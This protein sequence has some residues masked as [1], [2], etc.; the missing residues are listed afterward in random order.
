MRPYLPAA[1]ST[2]STRSAPCSRSIPCAAARPAKPTR[3][4]GQPA[5]PS[6]ALK[7]PPVLNGASAALTVEDRATSLDFADE[8][9][10]AQS[11]AYSPGFSSYDE[12]EETRTRLPVQSLD[13]VPLI[14]SRAGTPIMLRASL[15]L[16]R[17]MTRSPGWYESS[18]SLDMCGQELAACA[19]LDR[20]DGSG[21]KHIAFVRDLWAI[22]EDSDKKV[23][24]A[25]YVEVDDKATLDEPI[26]RGFYTGGGP[27]WPADS[28]VTLLVKAVDARGEFFLKSYP[29]PIVEGHS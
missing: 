17:L 25:S 18:S 6:A 3:P 2:P 23:W 22:H 20:A 26:G 12:A 21:R 1:T 5:P 11:P 19:Y 27:S 28:H 13:L 7:E 14:F 9:W 8:D 15:W 4:T 29:T 24:H 10:F 16:D